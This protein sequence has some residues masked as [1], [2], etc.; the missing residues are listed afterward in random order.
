MAR[1]AKEKPRDRERTIALAL[2]SRRHLARREAHQ[3]PDV[4][5]DDRVDLEGPLLLQ[6][7]VHLVDD[8]VDLGQ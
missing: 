2:L 1:N 8:A 6:V 3:E 5:I 4:V 7:F